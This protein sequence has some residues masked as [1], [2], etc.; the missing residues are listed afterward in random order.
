MIGL[1]SIILV[2]SGGLLS[3]FRNRSFV[4]IPIVGFYFQVFPFIG[5]LFAYYQGDN[6]IRSLFVVSFGIF[7]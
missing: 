5:I 4:A 7:L 3:Y 1:V 6:V 2:L